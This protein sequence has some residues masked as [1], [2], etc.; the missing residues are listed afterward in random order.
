SRK[1]VWSDLCRRRHPPPRKR[2]GCLTQ[3]IRTCRSRRDGRRDPLSCIV[4]VGGERFRRIATRGRVSS[5]LVRDCRRK[6]KITLDYYILSLKV[7]T[8]RLCLIGS[9]AGVTECAAQVAKPKTRQPGA[10]APNAVRRCLR[11]A[12][13]AALPTSPR[14]SS[15]AVAASR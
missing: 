11:R 5:A 3:R 6:P 13:I 7:F 9:P 1:S 14:R 12:G 8:P 2:E 4:S 10:F 15:A